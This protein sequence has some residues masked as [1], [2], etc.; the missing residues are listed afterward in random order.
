MGTGRGKEVSQAHRGVKTSENS[1]L[2]DQQYL[3]QTPYEGTV[4]PSHP[5]QG[6]SVDAKLQGIQREDGPDHSVL[7]AV[8]PCTVTGAGEQAHPR[9]SKTTCGP[10]PL[11]SEQ[12]H[13]F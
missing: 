12:V 1:L 4:H 10:R 6:R 8:V 9:H 2:W 11:T 7:T 3:V 5:R 13:A